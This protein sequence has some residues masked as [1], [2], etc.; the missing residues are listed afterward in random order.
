M[1]IITPNE[2]IKP[3]PDITAGPVS[4]VTKINNNYN[5][6]KEIIF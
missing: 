5:Y 2:I 4:D 6:S 1:R 3:A